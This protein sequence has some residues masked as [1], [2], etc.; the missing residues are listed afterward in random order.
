MASIQEANKEK[1]RSLFEDYI[2]TGQ[3]DKLAELIGPEYVGSLGDAG[4]SGIAK[5]VSA[6]RQ[7]FP[8]IHYT[9]DE[10]LAE[11]DRVAIRWTWKGTHR[12]A[13]QGFPASH[14]EITN[15]GV[16]TFQL[17]D[18]KIVRGWQQT[19]RLG[20]LQ[21]IGVVP[22]VADLAAEEQAKQGR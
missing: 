18:G 8:D 12:G 7:A 22:P 10:I 2:N 19:D 16:A 13:F 3:L 5:P 14:R 20:F 1:V 15:A 9:V 21:E 6:L 17:R 4:P 11:G